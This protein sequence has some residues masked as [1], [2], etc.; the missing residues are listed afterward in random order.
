M[1]ILKKTNIKERDRKI[2]RH[3]DNLF[4]HSDGEGD[5]GFLGY[6]SPSSS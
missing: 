6:L 3:K 2:G 5:W 1:R 4:P